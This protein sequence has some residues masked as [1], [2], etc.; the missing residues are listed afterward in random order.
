MDIRLCDDR[1]WE[2]DDLRNWAT[3]ARSGLLHVLSHLHGSL[4]GSQ[5]LL[6]AWSKN[7]LPQRADPLP[8][9]LLMALA[10]AALRAR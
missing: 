5:Q 6:I 8:T 1:V 2:Q 3:D 4:H 9:E 7:E 10:G